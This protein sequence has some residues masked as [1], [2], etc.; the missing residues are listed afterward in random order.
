MV[1]P[2]IRDSHTHDL[3]LCDKLT[4]T[5]LWLTHHYSYLL[6]EWSGAEK[7]SSRVPSSLVF[8]YCPSPIWLKSLYRSTKTGHL[9]NCPYQFLFLQWKFRQLPGSQV[10]L[11]CCCFHVQIL[12]LA[13]SPEYA[14]HE[15][16]WNGKKYYVNL[17]YNCCWLKWVIFTYLVCILHEI[18]W[19]R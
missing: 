5:A 11:P 16:G 15:C 9:Q 14:I 4:T 19:N 8:I 13:F 12:A 2:D 17:C 18:G 6:I 10:G 3:L 7:Y 1:E